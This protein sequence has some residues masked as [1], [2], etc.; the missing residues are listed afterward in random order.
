IAKPTPKNPKQLLKNSDPEKLPDNK[1]PVLQNK[2]PTV[3]PN[4]KKF[5]K[6]KLPD[7]EPET[8]AT[9]P[10]G[11][12]KPD[13]HDE[14]ELPAEEIAKP[15]PKNPKQLL[16]NSDP[17]KLPDNKK[18]V[19]QNKTPTVEPNKKK[20]PKVKLPDDEPETHA[21]LP[22]GK[23]KPDTHDEEELPAEEI[24]KP[25][26][27]NPKQL[28]KNSDPEK[29]PDNK[30][31]VLQ[32]KTPTVEPN[33]KKFPKVKLP[34]DEPE[35]HATLPLGKKKPDTHDEE[36]LP[37]EEIAKPTPKNPKQ[38]LKNSDF[39]KLPDNKKPVLQNKT[40][41]VEPNKKKF[42][43]VK[44]PDDE[45]EAHVTLPLGEEKSAEVENLPL[46]GNGT[47]P[48]N[49]KGK[50][51]R[52]PINSSQRTE[53]EPRNISAKPR[54]V[55]PVKAVEEYIPIPPPEKSLVQRN[56]E[57]RILPTQRYSK[58]KRSVDV[59][60]PFIIPWEQRPA[61]MTQEGMGAFGK[62]RDAAMKIGH[63]RKE[64]KQGNLKTE[65]VIP[66]LNDNRGLANR[67]GMLPFGSR[68]LN[69]GVVVDNHEFSNID[70]GSS[71]SIIPFVNRGTINHGHPS[72]GGI[73]PQV[74]DVEYTDKMNLDMNQM[75][76]GFISRYFAPHTKMN[77]GSN[78]MDRRRGEITPCGSESH[79][80]K[81]MIPLIFNTPAVEEKGSM[82][83]SFRPLFVNSTGGYCMKFDDELR[84]KNAIPFQT[85]PS[86]TA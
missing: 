73:R 43:K 15:T 11:N 29:L 60:I 68:R 65:T 53:N 44:F 27:K 63:G 14:E 33:K 22:L 58:K 72:I 19:L 59:Y 48:I 46:D 10:L 61:R 12:K 35:T 78:V 20:F 82:F 9:L 28:L 49:P 4:K 74:T 41:T 3:E 50:R 81:N 64:L 6:V 34:D 62:T 75:S 66:L 57:E 32:N 80:S 52:K 70:D 24:A 55:P 79:K 56:K 31:P 1:K 16:K 36:E 18:P 7:D 23:K 21:T 67:S 86:L 40:P 37:A 2:T 8:H 83:G 47:L 5:P 71:D 77:A 39:E 76:H 69:L 30:K 85:A 84:C 42:P 13:T 26:P 51:K 25:T 17:E 38:L 45:P 54:W